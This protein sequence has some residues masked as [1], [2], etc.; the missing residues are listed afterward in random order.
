[1]NK[2]HNQFAALYSSEQIRNLE[3]SAIEKYKLSQSILMERAGMATFKVLREIWRD[4]K[5]IAVICGKGNNGGDGYVLARLAHKANLAVTIFWIID[6]ESLDG[7]AKDAYLDAQKS[8]VKM[9]PFGEEKLANF[10]II[11][12][13]IFGTG[14]N[15]VI[16][17][18]YKNIIEAINQSKLPVLAIDA[19]SGLNVDTGAMMGVAVK[20]DVTVTFI[21]LKQG[22]FTYQGK[23][24]CGE[25]R[26]DQLSLADEL[27]QNNTG[28]AKPGP[29]RLLDFALLKKILP[30]RSRFAHKGDFGHVLLVGGDLGKPG[31]IRMAG[32]SALRV[33]AG[34]VTIA[35]RPE[36]VT[37]ACATRPEL[38]CLGINHNNISHIKQLIA[39]VEV[40]GIGP[41]L[42]VRH[43][44]KKLW[45]KVIKSKHQLVLD[46][47]ALNILAKKR[48]H[49]NNWIL[50]P[51]P[52]EAARLLK[53]TVAA[54]QNDRFFAVR[55]LQK[56]YG[57]VIVLKGSGTLICDSNQQVF[58]CPYGNPGMAKGGMGDVLTGILAGLLAQGLDLQ[59]AALFGVA[60][61]S[62]AADEAVMTM[63]ECSL[64]ATDLISMLIKVLNSK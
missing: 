60:L 43:F 47:D 33:G 53:C 13:A 63:P 28:V 25:V 12:D 9:E 4:Q 23:E 20:A 58:V 31:A 64:I 29:T 19:P 55:A 7:A 14:L 1:M 34:L 3:N 27:F 54:I 38:M 41:G 61:H 42:G 21:G 17:E 32:E 57:G 49:R 62:F 46:A 44:G 40:V 36:H 48:R 52:G 51:H 26:L 50:T 18:P 30:V 37:I 22:F 39:D 59:N 6:P 8:K 2:M 56:K 35:T 45:K 11:V 16:T 15:Q 5:R 10:D 24:F